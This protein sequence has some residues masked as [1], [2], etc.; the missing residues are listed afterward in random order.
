MPSVTTPAPPRR[1]WARVGRWLVRGVVTLLLVIVLIPLL[2]FASLRI[3]AVRTR[4]AS[5]VDSALVDSFKGRIRIESIDGVDFG[6]VAVHARVED[7]KGR[8]VITAHGAKVLVFWPRMVFDLITAE[9]PVT[10]HLDQIDIDH[11]EVRLIDDGTGSPTL[12]TAFDPKTPSPPSSE[13]PPTVELPAIRLKHAWIHGALAGAPPIDAE[14]SAFVAALR[15]DPKALNLEL[16]QVTLALRGLPYRAEPRGK[17]QAKLLMAANADEPE[18]EGAYRGTIAAVGIE[19]D[20]QY[21]GGKLLA[22]VFAKDIDQR[23]LA[24]FSPD[25]ALRGKAEALVRAEGTLPEI[26]FDADVRS[27]V[28]RVLAKGK[29]R[30]EE[31]LTLSANVQASNLDVSGVV[32]TAPVTGI[33]AT[34]DLT[35]RID[36]DRMDATY[37][38]SLPT[39]LLG[40]ERLPSVT[41]RGKLTQTPQLL[42]VEGDAEVDE[43]GA[44]TSL[45][46]RVEMREPNGFVEARTKTQLLNPKR[47]RTLAGVTAQGQVE[48]ALR[49]SLPKQELAGQVR[50]QL[51]QAR[52]GENRLGPTY[53]RVELAGTTEAPHFD[54]KVDAANAVALDRAFSR[55][56][57]SLI[58]TPTRALVNAHLYA[59][60]PNE[61][62]VSADLRLEDGLEVVAP[63]VTL[64]DGEGP[65][66]IQAT[67]VAA[68]DG[69]LDVDELTITG[70][71]TARAS[72]RQRGGSWRIKADTTALEVA[73][74]TRLAGV[75]TPVTS[76]RATLAV[77]A[78]LTPRLARGSVRGRIENL[79]FDAVKGGRADLDLKLEQQKLS[80]RVEARLS[81][82]GSAVLHIDELDV[83]NPPISLPEPDRLLARVRLEGTLDLDSLGPLLV[84]MPA[85]PIG[86]AKGRIV[87]DIVYERTSLEEPPRL[88]AK[89]RTQGLEISGKR[90]RKEPIQTTEEA[91][92]ANTWTYRGL[93]L[94]VSVALDARERRLLLVGKAHD[95]HGDLIHVDASA[96][97]LPPWAGFAAL[98]ANVTQIPLRVMIDVPERSFRRFPP[99]LRPL[100][101]RGK[102]SAQVDMRGTIDAPALTLS[103]NFRRMGAAAERIAGKRPERV[104]VDLT[105][106]YTPAGG[107]VNVRA[108]RGALNVA[109]V[110]ASWD[111][112]ARKFDATGKLTPVEVT[113]KAD[114]AK[115]ELETI[116]ALKNRQIGGRLSGSAAIVYGAAKRE[117]DVKL[118]AEQLELA[119][120]VL[121]RMETSVLLR[122]GALR[123]DVQVRGKAGSLDVGIQS[124]MSWK[125]SL[126]PQL[127]GAIDGKLTARGFRLGALSP[128]LVGTVSEL[129][130]RLDADLRARVEGDTPRFSGSGQLSDGVVQIPAVGQRFESISARIA[131]QPTEIRLEDVRAR[132]LSGGLTAASVLRFD[133]HLALRQATAAVRIAKNDKIPITTEGVAIGDA[134]GAIDID[135]RQVGEQQRLSVVVPEFHLEMPDSN[136]N[137]V[138]SLEPASDIRIGVFQEDK[139][140]AALPIQKLEDESGTPPNM[141]VNI[142][143]GENVWVRRGDM[144]DVQ[145]TGNLQAKV[146]DETSVTGQ[147]RL[148]DGTLDVQGKRFEIESGTVTFTGG[149]PANPTVTALARWEAPA[150][151]TVYANYAGTAE[152]GRL[153]LRSEPPLTEDEILSLI[154]FGSTDGNFGSGGGD[155]AATAV[156]LAGGTA[157]K[158]LNR[159]ISDLTNLDIQARIDTSTG[160]S[161]PEL[162]V[163]ITARLSARVTRAIGEPTPGASP[164]RTFLTLDLRLKR[165][166]V[167]SGLVGDRGASALDLIWR[168]RY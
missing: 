160:T 91:V 117:V 8:T 109:S 64:T 35:G 144:V 14:L 67:R 90:T 20:G 31:V 60:A 56:R 158:G 26:G 52:Q 43:P 93:D 113:L 45:E 18:V 137:S 6:R 25:L 159:A 7:E 3:E 12:I 62:R 126:T 83:G 122:D 85:V 143:L 121:D 119:Q 49:L 75:I 133:Q 74:I 105:A 164:D 99:G 53:A 16:K 165:N 80:G 110:D 78:E 27:D 103:A 88:E 138:Q 155:S 163:P 112:D 28:G 55:V 38:V 71:G 107:D 162:M 59:T 145:L 141:L 129:D 5:L 130:G 125:D 41:T 100:S 77:D 40:Q 87:T 156:G 58:G 149:D 70:A 168:H 17:L 48:T 72:L 166:W 47:L 81:R 30:L 111:G 13:P 15:N 154:L 124:G 132:G 148:R 51:D 128:L 97:P 69:S 23:T 115:F 22:K 44:R 61:L 142:E 66:R 1:G 161:R 131:V 86:E 152:D 57:L 95:T 84:S 11:V 33:D 147:I 2:A 153:T 82:A 9:G 135:M 32:P 24:R 92:A 140:F 123:G 4:V 139:K 76:A 79:D 96:Y 10:I 118:D 68:G 39:P 29:V 19:A 136:P 134:W 65:V 54:A 104:D 114:F 146:T 101:L 116:P 50:I 157:A 34:V 46:Y 150:G 94:N 106:K 42:S 73:R 167:L 63:D 108:R 127:D 37:D 120:V 98:Q 89:F 151:Y 36:G 21:R 102:M